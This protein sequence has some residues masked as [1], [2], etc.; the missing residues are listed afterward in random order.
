MTWALVT[1]ATAGI[2][3]AFVDHLAA[4]GHDIVLVARDADRLRET[5][6]QTSE[7]F[8]VRT[9][10]LVADLSDREA[11]GAVA[12]RL[13]SDAEPVEVLVNNAGYTPNQAFVTGDP[14]REQ[15]ALDGLDLRGRFRHILLPRLRPLLITVGFLLIA[16]GLATS[17]SLLM[18]TG[19][20]P[21]SATVT[22]GLFSYQQAVQS[23][24]W[25]LGSTSGWLI[26]VSVGL[27]AFGYLLINL[28][29]ARP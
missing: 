24:N 25:A 15:A 28:R 2:G 6:E 26:A 21:G 13:A 11:I 19:G 17:E 1:G 8:E 14:D 10:V 9:E 23:Y 7:R 22:L 29:E 18:L 16:D 20:G 27:F 5:A 12:R 4:Q 3:R